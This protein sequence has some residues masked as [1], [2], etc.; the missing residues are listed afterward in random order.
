MLT[1]V[2]L[3]VDLF[4]SAFSATPLS[5]LRVLRFSFVWLKVFNNHQVITKETYTP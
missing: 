1:V 4:I 5:V 2:S 3:V